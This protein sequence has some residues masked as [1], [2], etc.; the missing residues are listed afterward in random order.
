LPPISTIGLGRT[1]V[2]SLSREPKPPAKITAFI[3]VRVVDAAY[4]TTA[5]HRSLTPTTFDAPSKNGKAAS[6][7]DSTRN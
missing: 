3:V 1:A 7:F 2:S 5:P 6:Y 4:V